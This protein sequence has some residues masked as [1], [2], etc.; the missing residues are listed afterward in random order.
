[1]I[2]LDYFDEAIGVVEGFSI[3]EDLLRC[4]KINLFPTFV[5]TYAYR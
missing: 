2:R 3:F 4:G 1:M 5:V